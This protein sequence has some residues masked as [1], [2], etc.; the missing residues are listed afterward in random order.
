[1]AGKVRWDTGCLLANLGLLGAAVWACHLGLGAHRLR[2]AATF[3]VLGTISSLYGE[4][5]F[6]F[7]KTRA[8]RQKE[9]RVARG[10]RLRP[11]LWI[12]AGGPIAI[13][14]ASAP[15]A[16]MVSAVG[17]GQAGVGVLASVAALTATV[18]YF[19]LRHSCRSLAFE[20]GGL[21]LYLVETSFV[22]PWKSI[23]SADVTGQA[24]WKLVEVALFETASA[25]ASVQPDTLRMRQRVA[26]ALYGGDGSPGRIL[27][28][29]WAAG[30]DAPV[31]ARAIK[32]EMAGAGIGGLN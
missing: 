11:P 19:V 5:L 3:L 20:P 2:T 21:R 9:S 16:A 4:L 32:A 17:S 30:I 12:V 22:I 10:V 7:C 28:D 25:L 27:L 15:V 29:Q 8:R 6:H 23:A 18:G 1:M 26:L 24:E 14:A 31:L 13:L